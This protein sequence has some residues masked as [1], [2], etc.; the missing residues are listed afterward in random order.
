MPKQMLSTPNM[1]AFREKN[2]LT[3]H[4]S[5]SRHPKRHKTFNIPPTGIDNKQLYAIPNYLSLCFSKSISP[6]VLGRCFHSDTPIKY[7]RHYSQSVK[8]HAIPLFRLEKIK[9][10]RQ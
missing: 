9:K 5:L 8:K 2:V 6:N 10:L 7:Y 4:L 1:P 3:G